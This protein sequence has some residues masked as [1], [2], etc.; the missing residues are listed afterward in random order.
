MLNFSQLTL[1]RGARILIDDA[2]LSIHAGQRVGLVGRNGTGKSSLFA[3]MQYELAPDKGEFT[4]PRNWAVATV[5][6]ETPALPTP[7]LEYVLDG[8]QELRELETALA[9]A[10]AAHDA[11]RLSDLHE[12][13][14]QIDA[15][16]ARARAATLLDG[17]GFEQATHTQAVA[18]F[19]GGW[20]MRLNLARALMCRSDLLLLDEPTNHLDL[21]A[22]IWVQEWLAAYRG[23]LV[24]ISHDREFLDAVCT[25][26]LHL[27][28]ERLTLYAG[29]YSAFERV[30]AERLSQQAATRAAQ[31]RQVAHLQKFVDRFK[32]Q[33][34]KARQAQSRVKMIER[35]QLVA[36]VIADN[37]F[38]FSFRKP[39][40]MPS[41]LVRLNKVSVGYGGKA[42]LSGVNLGIEPGERIGLLGP[43]G[44]GKSTFVKLIAGKLEAMS[45]TVV[46]HPDLVVGYFDQHQLEQLDPAASAI[47]H[48]KRLDPQAREQDL[49]DYLG[50]FNFRG[51]RAYEA[52]EP[53]SGGEKARL[54]LALVVYPRPNLLLLDEPTNHL[55]LDMR[56]ALELALTD[57]DGAVVLVSHDRHLIASV[58]DRLW[59]VADH[60]VQ[61]FDGDLDDYSRWLSERGRKPAPG[62]GKLQKADAPQVAS[63]APKA[64]VSRDEVKRL[65]ETLR[66]T[67]ARQKRI[68]ELLRRLQQ[69][70]AEPTLY[71]RSDG[72]AEAAKLM[73]QQAE[74]QDELATVEE[75]W[76]ET[77][78]LLETQGA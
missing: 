51:D 42:Q 46:I 59:R 21:D 76:L 28:G 1:R 66:K 37:E 71:E 2:T 41:P 58:S 38:T 44:A 64:T 33:A 47:L 22:V 72:P 11:Q 26:T 73:K 34:T 63:A 31:E 15:Y 18:E 36:P 30:R 9:K 49:R 6:Q 68:E 12:R 40:K 10:E 14:Y 32:A 16:T 78:D 25:H 55:D 7:A 74:L 48:F 4:R 3:L 67:E 60:A 8:D 65:R 50:S 39:L 61:P 29:N 52:I 27:H 75:T 57:F 70:L 5:A 23:T 54:A 19:S 24:V 13:A 20:R 62:A 35:I 69:Q 43:N 56:Q 53:F 17:L 77:A 45:G